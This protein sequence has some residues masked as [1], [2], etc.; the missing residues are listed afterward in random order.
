MFLLSAQRYGDLQT[1]LTR[2]FVHLADAFIQ[3]NRETQQSA[4][5]S[6][7]RNMTRHQIQSSQIRR[8]GENR[9]EDSP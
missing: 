7:D 3:S 5:S 9:D 2:T 4:S 8:A 1:R 6:G